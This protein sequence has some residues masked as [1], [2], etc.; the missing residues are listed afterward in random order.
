MRSIVLAVA[1]DDSGA[2]TASELLSLELGSLT[3]A[4]V[5]AVWLVQAD[6]MAHTMSRTI[7][8]RFI[9]SQLLY[10]LTSQRQ[11]AEPSTAALPLGGSK[12]HPDLQLSTPVLRVPRFHNM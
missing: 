7:N 6:S 11:A 4:A 2:L 1:S 5:W 3:V 9:C 8:F 12:K 10:N